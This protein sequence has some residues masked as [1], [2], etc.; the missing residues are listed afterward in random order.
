M[1]WF[2]QVAAG[3]H[4]WGLTESGADPAS[5]GNPDGSGSAAR[6]VSPQLFSSDAYTTT[7]PQLAC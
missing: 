3:G 2:R 4:E 6:L 5:S 1:R 7:N